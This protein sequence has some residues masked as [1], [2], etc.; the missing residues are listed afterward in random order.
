MPI[1]LICK[2]CKKRFDAPQS[3]IKHY[4][5]SHPPRKYCSYACAVA[6]P[7]RMAHRRTTPE[8]RTCEQCGKPY[9]YIKGRN[10]KRYCSP[11]C[12]YK[13][14]NSGSLRKPETLIK[15]TCAYCGKAAERYQSQD[16][17]YSYLYCSQECHYNHRIAVYE[18]EWDGT[19][20][21]MR[22]KNWHSQRNKARKRDK[23]TCQHC[24]VTE[25]E[26]GCGLDVHHIIPLRT[27]KGD[28]KKANRLDNLISLCRSCHRSTEKSIT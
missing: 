8:T 18:S 6:D 19:S 11:E 16:R 27:F 13:A 21:D 7:E 12:D 28:W 26:L 23:Y 22:G 4:D 10:G 15:F 5:A 20:R 17:G 25:I 3:A 24:G 9:P 14:R 2:T 1:T